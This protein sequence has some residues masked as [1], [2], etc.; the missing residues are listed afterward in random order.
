MPRTRRY[1]SRLPSTRLW[2]QLKLQAPTVKHQLIMLDPV[3]IPLLPVDLDTLHVMALLLIAQTIG[4]DAESMVAV[5]R[6]VD[7]IKPRRANKEYRLCYDGIE[8]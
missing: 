5:D 2:S 3:L 8:A 6:H 1:L 4:G 7:I